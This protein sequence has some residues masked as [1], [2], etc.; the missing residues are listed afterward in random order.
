MKQLLKYAFW[1]FI[2][3]I[4]GV[5]C[6]S[7]FAVK[8]YINSGFTAI[9]IGIII[10]VFTALNYNRRNA[11]FYWMSA[12]VSSLFAYY[13]GKYIIFEFYSGQIDIHAELNI[14]ATIGLI[15]LK[16]TIGSIVAFAKHH[17]ANYDFFDFLWPTTTLA[18]GLYH[19]RKVVP[20][21]QRWNK[22][23]KV[24]GR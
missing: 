13:L 24:F 17:I 11:I 19:A 6:W 7:Y 21:K 2:I 22:V 16:S 5:F 14:P 15:V 9:F 4:L 3:L 23:L 20:Y 18:M 10:G 8:L 1:T 12:G